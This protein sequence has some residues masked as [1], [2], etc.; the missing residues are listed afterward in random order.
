[1]PKVTYYPATADR[2][3]SPAIW[4]KYEGWIDEIRH[5]DVKLGALLEED[6]MGGTGGTLATATEQGDWTGTI[7]TDGTI[8]RGVTS[9]GTIILT[10]GASDDRGPQ[11]QN[12]SFPIVPAAGKV[13]VYECRAKASVITQEQ[14]FMGLATIDTAVFAAGVIDVTN[15]IG[16]LSQETLTTAAKLDLWSE[17]ATVAE[18]S[19]SVATMAADT[20]FKVGFVINGVTSLTAYVNNVVVSNGAIVIAT[21]LPVAAMVPTF[22]SLRENAAVLLTVDWVRCAYLT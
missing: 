8:T 2:E 22:A 13:I 1:M 18:D 17:K 20:Y 16:F 6:F 11:L 21:H 12:E 19:N 9:D 10:A 3:F 4:S 7:A 5:G 15:A 14:L